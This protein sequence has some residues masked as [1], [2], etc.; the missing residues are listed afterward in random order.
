MDIEISSPINI[1]MDVM[2][3]DEH[4]PSL[5]F[6]ITIRVEKFSYSSEVNS[7]L[8]IECQCFDDFVDSMRRGGIA[9]LKDM[10]GFFELRVNPAQSWLEWSCS[11][12]DLEGYFA[13]VQG[14]EKLTEQSMRTLYEAFNDYPKWW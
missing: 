3:L 6:S 14:K 11:K 10:N 1:K 7:Q 2:E 8:W 12:E 13:S 5:K 4:V 9:V